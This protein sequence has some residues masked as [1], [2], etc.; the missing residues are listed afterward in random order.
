MPLPS[1]WFPRRAGSWLGWS[2]TALA[3]AVAPIALP[4]AQAAPEGEEAAPDSPKAQADALSDD[5]VQK[6]YNK[7]YEA[8]IDLFLQAYELD[9]QPNYLF[10][11]GRVY[12]ESGDL[13]KAVEFYERFVSSPGVDLDAR[14]N[15]TERL[16]VL[17]GA[18]DALDKDDGDDEELEPGP[19]P[20][21]DEPVVD[22]EPEAQPKTDGKKKL[23]IAGY[24]LL[25]VGGAALI[26]GGVFGGL[27]SGKTN[28]ADDEQFVDNALDLRAE[29]RTQAVVADA[30]FIS[31]GV[32]AATGL[33]LVLS[34]L[35][36]KKQA[37]T[38]RQ[39]GN[40]RGTAAVWTPFASTRSAGLSVS[41]RF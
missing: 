21:P 26:V 28:D 1:V 4:T 41:G 19:Q 17:Q 7:E 8:A 37:D 40:R 5:A 38:A 11:I 3:L 30:M 2:A 32:L 36:G 24:S 6:F 27:A 31:G 15:A 29:A 39:R 34:T 16:K 9:E 35:G 33:V 20:P 25:G 18:V 14:Q 12:E 23:R 10:N 13:A 22:Q